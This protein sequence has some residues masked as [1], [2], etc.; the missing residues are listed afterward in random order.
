MNQIT[1]CSYEGSPSSDVKD[2]VFDAYQYLVNEKHPPDYLTFPQFLPHWLLEQWFDSPV[3]VDEIL[4]TMSNA[5]DLAEISRGIKR[6]IAALPD[7]RPV[8]N[9]FNPIILGMEL[10]LRLAAVSPVIAERAG[11]NQRV[12]VGRK[13]KA[14]SYIPLYDINNEDDFAA[15]CYVVINHY[16]PPS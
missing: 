1:A 8:P 7:K 9:T 11:P 12:V 14:R 13:R 5:I 2:S 3:E 15:K 6:R 10:K 16:N 4:V